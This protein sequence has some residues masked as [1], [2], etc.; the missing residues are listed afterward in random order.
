[1]GRK[2]LKINQRRCASACIPTIAETII[3]IIVSRSWLSLFRC[4]KWYAKM[5]LTGVCTAR[6]HSHRRRQLPFGLFVFFLLFCSVLFRFM[7]WFSHL[8]RRCWQQNVWSSGGSHTNTQPKPRPESGRKSY[9]IVWRR[10][11]HRR[12]RTTAAMDVV[13]TTISFC[14]RRSRL[15]KCMYMPPL[16]TINMRRKT[17]A[18]DRLVQCTLRYGT[19][20]QANGRNI[21][22]S[23][24]E[25]IH[26]SFVR[27][28]FWSF[29]RIARCSVR[30]RHCACIRAVAAA[31]AVER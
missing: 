23:D 28:V 16:P 21:C 26:C 30:S 20:W 14:V 7:H 4:A 9:W 3:I 2:D 6:T 25:T 1:M 10:Q 5:C 15:K 18:N 27:M 17:H 19:K 11:G 29:M 22:R 24:K 13:P 12:H 8:C 31:A